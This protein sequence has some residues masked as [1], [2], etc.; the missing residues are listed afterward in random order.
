MEPPLKLILSDR[1]GF[2]VHLERCIGTIK[3]K[4]NAETAKISQIDVLIF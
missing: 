3:L 2:P 1:F 4:Y